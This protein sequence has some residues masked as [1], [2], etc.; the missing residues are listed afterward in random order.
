MVLFDF[1]SEGSCEG[2]TWCQA[3]ATVEHHCIVLCTSKQNHSFLS[4]QIESGFV[5][6]RRERYSLRSGILPQRAGQK[7]EFKYLT[8]IE[9]QAGPTLSCAKARTRIFY[10]PTNNTER[11]TNNEQH[12][13]TNE[14]EPNGQTWIAPRH[15]PRVLAAP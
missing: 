1:S 6:Q 2:A 10:R 11:R 13:V 5:L 14:Q 12:R 15:Y 4:L 7:V 8:R 9:K 3:R